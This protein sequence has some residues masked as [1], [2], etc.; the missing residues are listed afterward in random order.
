L[1]K[2][3]KSDDNSLTLYSE[4]FGDVYHSVKGPITEAYYI[5]IQNGLNNINRKIVSILDVGFGTGLNGLLTYHNSY[6]TNKEIFYTA[7][8]YYPLELKII[9]KLNYANLINPFLNDIYLEM[10]KMPFNTYKTICPHF[11]FLKLKIDLTKDF[12][13]PHY[14]DLIYYD[15]FSPNV[16][17]EMWRQA[18]LNYLYTK[19]NNNSL[20]VTYCSKGLV[21]RNLSK[22]EFKVLKQKGILNK[23]H[24]TI[25]IKD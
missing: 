14:Y 11:N 5:Y 20:L 9:K 3:I 21:R 23:R 16:Q 24:I 1:I 8:E 7:I 12:Y 18:I 2:F 10:H 22:I 17:P 4:R 25:A 13:L 19:L 15:P 6:K